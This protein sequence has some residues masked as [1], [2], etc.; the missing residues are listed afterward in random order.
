MNYSS[1]IIAN[2]ALQRLGARGTISALTENIPNAIKVNTVWEPV[3]MEVLSERDWNFAKLRVRIN[4]VTTAPLY[5]Y[6]YAYSMPTD[7]LRLVRPRPRE[8]DQRRIYT[9]LNWPYGHDH[10]VSPVFVHPY[11]IEMIPN[12][13]GQR[14]LLTDH[15][16]NDYPIYI[17]YIQILT[18]LT[19]VTPTFVNSLAWRLAAEIAVA[20]TEDKNK[21]E[22]AMAEYRNSLNTS[23]AVNDQAN[24]LHD[25]AGGHE[26]VRAGRWGWR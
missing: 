15:N 18:D 4:Q 16:D 13:D 8:D 20:I 23:S 25:E 9:V 7:Y 6:A 1:V 2:L 19:R 12:S 10:P 3:F 5:G 11:V 26:W 21:G 22:A 14:C 24:Y 17:N